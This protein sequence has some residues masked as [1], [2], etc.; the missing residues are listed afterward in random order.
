MT[1]QVI[2]GVLGAGG[3]SGIITSLLTGLSQRPKV[4]ADAVAAL[5]DSA[6]RQVDELQDRTKE[7]EQ[8]AKDARVEME[9]AERKA[10]Q[11]S[12]SFDALMARMALWRSEIL[13]ANTVDDLG[14]LRTMVRTDPGPMPSSNGVGRH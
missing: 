2:V 13:S 10:R 6:M 4:R 5:T 9:R 14:W 11:L 7:A 12:A 8:A 3:L 1:W